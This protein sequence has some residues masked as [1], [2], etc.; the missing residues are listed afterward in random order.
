MEYQ[1]I[2]N[3]LDNKSNQPSKFRTKNWVEINEDRNGVYLDIVMSTYNL[4]EYS[5]NYAKTSAN[6]WQNCRDVADDNIAE[7]KS[8]KSSITDNTNNTGIG[9]VKIVV[10]LKYLSNF[11]R[12]VE[13]PLI[14]CEVK[15]DLNWSENCVICEA[16]RTTTFAMT[17]AK[18]Y[19]PVVTLSIQ[20]NAKLLQQ[21]YAGFKRTIN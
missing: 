11:W 7:S 6:L 9:N 5:E 15:L 8:F 3:L 19:I 16:N 14:N 1:K 21:L 13:M 18:R 12:T 20:D 2:I 17:S 10:P 4:L